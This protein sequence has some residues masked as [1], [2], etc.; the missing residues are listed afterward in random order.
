MSIF[1]ETVERI[2]AAHVTPALIEASERGEAPAA[3]M[4][5]LDENGLFDLLVPESQGGIGATM[6]DAVAC[7][8]SIGAAAA[9]G[10]ILETMIE[11]AYLEHDD[12]RSGRSSRAKTRDVIE[13]SR[14]VLGAPEEVLGFART[15]PSSSLGM[16]GI[17]PID[18]MKHHPNLKSEEAHQTAALLNAA[19]ISGAIRWIFERTATYATE[20]VQFGKPLGKQQAVQQMLALLADHMLAG[21]AIT[22]AAAANPSP[23]LIAAARARLGE[24]SDCAIEVGHQVHGAIGFTREY[25]LNYR[26]RN[27]ITWRD[28]Y[29]SVLEWKA[30]LGRMFIGVSRDEL[31]P[32]ITGDAT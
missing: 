3:L 24:A 20:R 9:P 8:R 18:S 22:D 27:L 11:R 6:A 32:S 21:A 23:R 31:W 10:P 28:Q 25:A 14:D 7:L 12:F 5:A 19:R 26:T 16:S 17:E 13:R 15:S 29:G 4:A 2:L 30:E 1:V